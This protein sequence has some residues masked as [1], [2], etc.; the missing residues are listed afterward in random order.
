[1]MRDFGRIVQGEGLRL[2]MR[3]S[4]CVHLALRRGLYHII[5]LISDT[6]GVTGVL[7]FKL[8]SNRARIRVHTRALN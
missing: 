1:M 3:E 5:P 6:R 4:V 7:T 8:L 2:S